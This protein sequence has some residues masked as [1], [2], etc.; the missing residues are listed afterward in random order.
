MASGGSVYRARERH[1]QAGTD[2]GWGWGEGGGAE[3]VQVVVVMVVVVVS[4]RSPCQVNW[5]RN[6]R[7]A[8][9]YYHG[10]LELS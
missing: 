4:R 9:T 8:A 5:N 2:S 3:D 6:G 10:L 1:G 7:S